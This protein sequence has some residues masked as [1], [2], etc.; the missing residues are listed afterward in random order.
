MFF[1][2]V[3]LIE[4][5]TMKS[6]CFKTRDSGIDVYSRVSYKIKMGCGDLPVVV[7][8]SHC[9]IAPHFP[10]PHPSFL[11]ALYINKVVMTLY[12]RFPF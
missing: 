3:F 9:L 6:I 8:C 1:V 4:G 2:F 12:L 5:M 7:T 10:S 11:C